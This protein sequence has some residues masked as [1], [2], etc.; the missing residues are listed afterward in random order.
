LVDFAFQH[1]FSAFNNQKNLSTSLNEIALEEAEYILNFIGGDGE[2][3]VFN[4]PS[5]DI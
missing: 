2:D 1:V 3:C 4:K 5:I